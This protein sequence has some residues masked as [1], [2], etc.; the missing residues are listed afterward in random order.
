MKQLLK[1]LTIFIFAPLFA[2]SVVSCSE[3]TNP[4]PNINSVASKIEKHGLI[5]LKDSNLD[6]KLNNET[7]KDIKNSLELTSYESD[8][9]HIFLLDNNKLIPNSNPVFIKFIIV[10]NNQQITIYQNIVWYKEI[11]NI[12]NNSKIENILFENNVNLK[13]NNNN[14]TIND[15]YFLSYIVYIFLISYLEFKEKIN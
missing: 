11:F 1:L 7:I 6:G 9:V 5:I 4:L 15:L 14:Q 8:M 2:Y 10:N 13:I 3:F 12:E